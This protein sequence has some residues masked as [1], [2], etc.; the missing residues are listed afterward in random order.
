[1][2]RRLR[3]LHAVL[4]LPLVALG[5]WIA[6]RATRLR[7]DPAA[8][9]L[10]LRASHGPTLPT[11][12]D[13]QATLRSEPETYDP[14]TLYDFID[15]AAD[16]YVAR[17]FERCA[18]ANYTFAGASGTGFDVSAELHRFGNE[19]GAREQMN[20]ERP[21]QATPVP[22]LQNAFSDAFTLVA[23]RERDYLKLTVLGSDSTA[24]E[25]LVRLARA[26]LDRSAK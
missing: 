12:K 16:A 2:P 22:G 25:T 3:V 24:P 15:G 11:A 6:Q 14:K 8:V 10:A 4:L 7:D 20:A 1:M 23:T 9:L 26:W 17:G 5:L 13:A 21:T 18:T 19:R